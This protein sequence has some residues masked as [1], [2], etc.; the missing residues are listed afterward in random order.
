M[1]RLLSITASVLLLAFLAACG[2]PAPA[3]TEEPAAAI[4]NPI[5]ETDENGL[6][7]AT[8]IP[9]PAPE[10]AT[11]LS[12]CYIELTGETPIAQMNFTLDGKKA[13]LRAQATAQTDPADISGL[14]Y[15]WTTVADAEV[16]YCKAVVYTNGEAGYISWVDVVPG[17]LYNLCMTQGASET[18]LTKLANTVFVPVQGDV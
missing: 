6:I 12:W 3:P 18:E 7:E 9:L 15:D 16:A 5:H 17:L 8:G 13:F 1:K 14:Y 10:D 2:A 11:E 4:S